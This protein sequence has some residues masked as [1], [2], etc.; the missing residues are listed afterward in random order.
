M[1]AER[2]DLRVG[3]TGLLNRRTG[4]AGSR[5]YV[6]LSRSAAMTEV[7]SSLYYRCSAS[8][9]AIAVIEYNTG[10]ARSTAPRRAGG[11]DRSPCRAAASSPPDILLTLQPFP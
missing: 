11:P 9:L 10:Y 1:A 3:R 8:G 7:G 5:E 2:Q 6:A 4:E